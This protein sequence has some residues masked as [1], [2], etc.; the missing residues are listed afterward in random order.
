VVCSKI[1][2]DA[3]KAAVERISAPQQKQ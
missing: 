3:T 2:A 1:G